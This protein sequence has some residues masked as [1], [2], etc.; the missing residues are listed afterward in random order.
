MATFKNTNINDTG[1]LQLPS[2]N[3]AQRPASPLAGMI[4][5]NTSIQDTEYYDGSGWRSISETNP[6]ASGGDI[7]DTEIA[8][9]AYRI[10]MFKSTGNSTFTVTKGGEVEYLIVA[11]GGGG[12][13]DHGG[14]GGAGGLLQGVTN[15]TAQAYTIAV[16][17]GGTGSPAVRSAASGPGANGGNSTAFGLTAIGGGGG[18]GGSAASSTNGQTGGSG[19]GGSGYGNP[20]LAGAGTAGQ[21]NNGGGGGAGNAPDYQGSGGG[22]AG[23]VGRNGSSTAINPDGGQGI[24][25]S[26]TGTNTYFAGGG[27]GCSGY[28][29]LGT[30]GYGGNGGGGNGATGGA[31]TGGTR[32]A[33]NG[34]PNTGGGGGG[35]NRHAAGG[36]RHTAQSVGPA[37]SGGS[38]I[39]IIRYRKNKNITEAPNVIK[40]SLPS[41]S[42]F[43]TK[44]PAKSAKQIT[45]LGL[46]NGWYWVDLS[47]PKLVYVNTKFS[48]GGW[49]LITQNRTGN[50]G[51]GTIN[52][53]DAI[54]SKQF[55]KTQ[56][57][58]ETTLVKERDL[59]T[60]NLWTG[61]KLWEEMTGGKGTGGQVAQVVYTS[62]T[63]LDG[64][65]TKRATWSYSSFSERYAFQGATG[66][67]SNSNN[68]GLYGY[69]AANGYNLTTHD[70]DQDASGG[71][72]ANNYGGHPMWFGACWSGNVWGSTAG[73][74]ADAYFW[75]GSGSD[76]FNYGAV[77]VRAL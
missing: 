4:R 64:L 10:H 1:L 66:V 56:Y 55:Y 51:I 26:I 58:L 73:G 45:D 46:P 21:G 14:G 52:Y 44:N 47:G 70:R 7:I 53:V 17:A 9:V 2:G 49:Y 59:G 22:G 54:D 13:N 63:D 35:A 32:P 61:M 62:P 20:R 12:G 69:H 41:A 37:G 76:Y 15:V 34:Q 24:V 23:S 36:P 77:Y 29:T 8:G 6:E 19:G 75:D 71:N 68:P 18:G 25:S 30:F 27:G 60:F 57:G 65:N 39:V 3:T 31:A 43:T 33:E 38:G 5:Y 40:S 67:S 74:Y 42:G 72:C 11:G 16:G 50:G 48:G 28:D